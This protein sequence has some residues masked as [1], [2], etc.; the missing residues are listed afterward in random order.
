[1]SFMAACFIGAGLIAYTSLD[2]FFGEELHPF[3]L[4]KLP[5]PHESLWLAALK[6]HVIAAVFTLPACTLLLS[7][8]LLRRWPRVHRWLGRITG[9]AVLGALVPSGAWLALFA[10]GDLAGTLGFLLSGLIIAVAMVNAVRH[11]RARRFALHQR[12]MWHVMAQMS[13]AV[14]SRALMLVLDQT[15]LDETVT[16]LVALW[17]PVIG[18]AALVEWL[19]P[20]AT[21]LR[22]PA[23]EKRPGV[24]VVPAVA[25]RLRR[26]PV[27]LGQ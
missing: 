12:S 11:A 6:T 2:Y 23:H 20:P 10:K 3:I 19:C 1:M 24:T 4:E 8:G 13:V 16:Y 22:T 5:L 15:P 26:A 25:E 17:V 9:L 18:S 14:S 7:R 27:T 21:S